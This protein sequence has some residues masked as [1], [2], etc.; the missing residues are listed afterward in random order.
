MINH[1]LWGGKIKP[2][3]GTGRVVRFGVGEIDIN[4][5]TGTLHER[6][7]NLLTRISDPMTAAEI[8]HKIGSNAS[9][10]STMLKKMLAAGEVD[11]ISIEGCHREYVWRDKN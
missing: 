6:I 2:Q 11:S 3:D 5:A 8:A 9:Q 4:I 10:V 1:L 7:E